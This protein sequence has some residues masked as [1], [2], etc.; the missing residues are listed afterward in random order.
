[1]SLLGFIQYNV[2][3]KSLYG[4][5][6]VKHYCFHLLIINCKYISWLQL[7]SLKSTL[8]LSYSP[9]DY[10]SVANFYV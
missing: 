3:V 1:M 9:V 4:A 10:L 7:D 5:E 8:E 6:K 2:N